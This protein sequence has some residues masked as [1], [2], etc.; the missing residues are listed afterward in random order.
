VPNR[1]PPR[2]FLK[3]QTKTKRATKKVDWLGALL[4]FAGLLSFYC[5]LFPESAG[6]IGRNTVK[7]LGWLAGGGRYFIPLYI[8]AIGLS[9]LSKN[10]KRPTAL[11]L[12]LSLMLFGCV[13]V[14][15]T[16][17]SQA[18]W[19]ENHGGVIG[20]AG[21][22]LFQ[23]LF[24]NV[25][26]W[27]IVGGL[28]ATFTILLAGMSPGDVLSRF[29][30]LLVNDWHEWR[31]VRATSPVRREKKAPI[32][33]SKIQAQPPVVQAPKPSAPPKIMTHTP[34]T[35]TPRPERPRAPAPVRDSKESAVVA[36]APTPKKPYQPPAL[37]IFETMGGTF[38]VPKEELR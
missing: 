14:L 6:F 9:L 20:Q 21:V 33:Q 37:D 7:F 2:F 24:G 12:I 13:L 15:F 29:K 16:L 1:Y 28:I 4:L 30:E 26:S 22:A 3:T 38:S 19:L 34:E 31:N 5:V 32:V 8:G 17:V 11:P 23:R 36:S 25:G 18:V 35:S 10:L 27:I